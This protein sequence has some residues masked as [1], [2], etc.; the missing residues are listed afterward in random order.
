MKRSLDREIT[1]LMRQELLKKLMV[2]SLSYSNA[3]NILSNLKV[4]IMPQMSSF[5]KRK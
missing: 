1:K 4:L 3:S 2:S 5:M